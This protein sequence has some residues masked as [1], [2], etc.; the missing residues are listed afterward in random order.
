MNT[1]SGNKTGSNG[2]KL[3]REESRP[4]SDDSALYVM[5]LETLNHGDCR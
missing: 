5:R 3:M 4:G 1:M 2:M